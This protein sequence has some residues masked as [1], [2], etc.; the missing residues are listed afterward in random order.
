MKG[1]CNEGTR[2][3]EIIDVLYAM[4]KFGNVKRKRDFLEIAAEWFM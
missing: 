4:R 2:K 3:S 1:I